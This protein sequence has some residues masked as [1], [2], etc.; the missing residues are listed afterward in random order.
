MADGI[1]IHKG[2]HGMDALPK[3]LSSETIADNLAVSWNTSMRACGDGY[4]WK[5]R[6]AAWQG[7][8]DIPILEYLRYARDRNSY[9]QIVVNTRGIG[10]GNGSTWEYTDQTPTTLA[11]LAADLVYYC[12]VLVQTKRQGDPLTTREQNLL[13]SLDW[14]SYDKLL[15]PGEPPVPRVEY[16]EIGNEPEGPYPPPAMSAEEYGDRYAVITGAMLAEDPTIKVGPSY[17]NAYSVD[18]INA[19]LTNPYVQVDFLVHHSYGGLYHTIRENTGGYL[20]PSA[21]MKSLRIEKARQHGRID[22]AAA[23]IADAGYPADLPQIISETNPSDWRGTYYYN[24]S[25]TVIHGLGVAETIFSYIQKNLVASQYWDLPNKSIDPD[26]D[27]P[28]FMVYQALQAYLR[29]VLLDSLAD[30]HFRLYTTRDTETDQVIVWAINFSDSADKPVR[31][32]LQNLPRP[33]VGILHRKLAALSGETSL[34]MLNTADA[35]VGWTETDLTGQIDPADFT[36]TFDHGTLSMIVVD[37]EPTS[38]ADLDRD[39]DVD[40]EDFGHLQACLSG[41]DVT[42]T[43]PDCQDADLDSDGDVDGSDVGI[44][45]GCMTGAGVPVDPNCPS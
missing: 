38:R 20:D 45:Q 30:G 7:S 25:Q 34:T 17:I 41:V 6:T 35:P 27:T 1:V 36:M 44:L 29:G 14:G 42:Q 2:V 5:T 21:L 11:D 3:Q 37:L 9:L 28:G 22:A 23:N 24:L 32:R 13:D 8:N 4:N 33:V 16:W 26:R 18:Y 31:I 39:G 15:A 19:V 12:N 43:D 40:Q 10:T